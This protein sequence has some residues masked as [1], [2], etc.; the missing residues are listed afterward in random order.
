MTYITDNFQVES[1]YQGFSEPDG[2]GAFDNYDEPEEQ[3]CSKCLEILEECECEYYDR[4][5]FVELAKERAENAMS[6]LKPVS[7][8]IN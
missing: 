3:I 7:M 1:F 8:E 2:Y 4:L 6:R 5:D